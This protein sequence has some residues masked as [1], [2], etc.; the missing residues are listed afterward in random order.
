MA[1][2][3]TPPFLAGFNI[4]KSYLDISGVIYAAKI[5]EVKSFMRKSV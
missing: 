5:T 3:K 1:I 4:T 2:K